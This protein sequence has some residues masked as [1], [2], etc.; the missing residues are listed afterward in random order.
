[1]G[2]RLRALLAGVS[3][4]AGLHLELG[5]TAEAV[6]LIPDA[7]LAGLVEGSFILASEQRADGGLTFAG[8]GAVTGEL[9]GAAL[10]RGSSYAAYAVLG[11]L[12]FAF[13]HPLRPVVPEAVRGVQAG[14][15]KVES[16]R[17][18]ERG[19]HYHTEH[20]LELTE[21]LNGFDSSGPEMTESWESMMPQVELFMEWLVANRQTKLEYILLWAAE[22]S[23]FAW[24]ATRMQRIR[25]VTSLAHNFTVE[26][27][28]DV[29]IAEK[30]QHAWYMTNA[31]GDLEGEKASIRSHLDWV[32]SAGFDFVA[33]E[34]GFSEFTHP[35]DT[36]MLE[37]MNFTTA[38]LADT[39]GAQLFIKAHC[40]TGQVCNNY[41]DPRT[42]KPLNFNF[43][44]MYAD[45]R[46]GVLPHTVQ[47]YALTGPAPTYGNSNF[48]Y[49][50]DFLLY[51]SGKRP[52]LY[53]G[54]TAYWVNYDID[55]PLLL[56][57]YGDRRLFDLRLIAQREKALGKH[58]DGQMNFESGWEWGYWLSN[59]L[60]ARAAWNPHSEL[61]HVAAYRKLLSPML[62]VFGSKAAAAAEEAIV[63]LVAAQQQLFID[64]VV[65]GVPPQTVERN[66]AQAYLQGW[67]TWAQLV[68][69]YNIHHG[70]TQPNKVAFDKL[71]ASSDP[72]L[73][74]V[75]ALLAA[76]QRALD[77]TVADLAAVVDSVP[78]SSAYLFHDLFSAARMTQLRAQQVLLLVRAA[79]GH[80]SRA[81]RLALLDRARAVT[82][83][84]EEEVRAAE[85]RYPVPVQRIAGW[86]KNP[87]VYNYGYL[88]AVHSVYYW[89]RDYAQVSGLL[90]G[91]SVTSSP[92]YLNLVNP[93]E[94]SGVASPALER[95]AQSVRSFVDVKLKFGQ[96][97]LD[98][99]GAPHS[100]PQ[101]PDDL[102]LTADDALAIDMRRRAA[103][104]QPP[105]EGD[106]LPQA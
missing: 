14:L 65:D 102:Q 31:T 71:D 95:L 37:W 59:T 82:F 20:P 54:E 80:G 81:S 70:R 93:V 97:L 67:S 28:A 4:P 101:L 66:T 104:L 8:R 11:K 24:S 89:W 56:P 86:R 25:T 73:D 92:C 35:D 17:W 6:R 40:S 1:M 64:G 51:E 33:T 75:L 100:E 72:S 45:A 44:P 91:E 69:K 57:I 13:L 84:A 32:M 46:L 98:C 74:R 49:M 68:Y 88:W 87:T 63:Q 53:H 58:M 16:P 12:G 41:E 85:A 50:L 76:T 47:F 38:Y 99:L 105:V 29:P 3:L 96:Q 62:A 52:V 36:L 39:Y 26:V 5:S 43:L 106:A 48:T 103:A 34:S 90:H 42:G 18:A 77:S 21:V 22:W 19:W 23:D 27:G 78:A 2:A 94:V 7:K 79:A 9:W 55:V 61:S 83:Q 60:T 15:W 10:S 30:Q